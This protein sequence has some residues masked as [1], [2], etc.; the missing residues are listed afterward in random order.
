MGF[1]ET[2]GMCGYTIRCVCF[3]KELYNNYYYC[4][5]GV[6]VKNISQNKKLQE[7]RDERKKLSE[8]S[9]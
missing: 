7:I 4:Y 9:V 1:L 8:Y 3:D 5:Y 6:E 2:R